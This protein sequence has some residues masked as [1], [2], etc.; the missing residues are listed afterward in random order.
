VLSGC[1]QSTPPSTAASET[2]TA[3]AAQPPPVATE[4]ERTLAEARK[5]RDLAVAEPAPTYRGPGDR[6]SSLAF[7]KVEVKAWLERAYPKAERAINAYKRALFA[8]SSDD[9]RGLALLEGANVFRWYADEFVRAGTGAIPAKVRAATRLNRSYVEELRDGV[10]PQ[11]RGARNALQECVELPRAGAVKDRCR[12]ALAE[13]S[14]K[15]PAPSTA[16]DDSEPP[17]RPFLA[18]T[19]PSP[20]TYAGSLDVRGVLYAS[21]SGAVAVAALDGVAGV[22]VAELSPPAAPGKRAKLRIQWPIELT[23]WL[24]AD[25]T[26]L[27]LGRRVD[28]VRDHVF[29]NVGFP[30][31]SSGPTGDMLEVHA[32]FQKE[33]PGIEPKAYDGRLPCS[34]LELTGRP[35]DSGGLFKDWKALRTGKVTLHDAP[36]GAKVAVLAQ[37]GTYAGKSNE[38]WVRVSGVEPFV[39]DGWIR[40]TDLGTEPGPTEIMYAMSSS[41]THLVTKP[42]PIRTTDDPRQAPF[43]AL[44]PG[45][46][47][48]LGKTKG[49]SVEVFS[50]AA[51]GGA[52]KMSASA[53]AADHKL[54]NWLPPFFARAADVA[55]STELVK[56]PQTA[57]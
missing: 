53:F 52:P 57:K 34:E 19:R 12:S 39:Y 51:I 3:P 20:C 32:D 23:A 56:K 30:L 36:N 21:E 7:F 38:G 33:Y 17:S 40:A 1:S 14:E 46:P 29:L 27:A 9:E 28:V 24:D 16:K 55:S 4:F 54:A 5:E 22:E 10:E 41:H 35:R 47:I 31:Q 45:A 49:E 8:A 26:P 2:A 48:R 13:L 25:A 43:G 44:A 37:K 50:T 11:Y 15:P 42:L 18:T 6:E